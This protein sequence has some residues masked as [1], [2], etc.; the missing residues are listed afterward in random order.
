MSTSVPSRVR[1]QTGPPRPGAAAS[2]GRAAPAT[3]VESVFEARD[4][5]VYYGS[6]RA[7]SGR[8]PAASRAAGSPP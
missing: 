2:R 3:P 5:S 7:L 4:V 8:Q 6:K 1:I